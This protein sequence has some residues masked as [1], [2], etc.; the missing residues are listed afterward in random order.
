MYDEELENKLIKRTRFLDP[1][2]N[3]A[4]LGEWHFM[5]RAQRFNKA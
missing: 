5:L 1:V 3:S 4:I 2:I